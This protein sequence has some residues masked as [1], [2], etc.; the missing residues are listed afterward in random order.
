MNFETDTETE[1]DYLPL[2][3]A[4]LPVQFA[5]IWHG[6]APCAFK[7]LAAAV[8]AQAVSDL[9]HYRNARNGRRQRLYN[10]AYRWVSSYSRSHPF[11]FVNICE[12]LELSPAAVRACLM[13]KGIDQRGS[14]AQAA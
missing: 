12:L 10:D 4:V 13:G 6:R 9:R 2:P 8:L 3:L 5:G 14:M 7:N 11:S 1:A